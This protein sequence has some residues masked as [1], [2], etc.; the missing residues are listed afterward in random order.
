MIC[1]QNGKD[2]LAKSNYSIF[3]H[4]F[5][6]D[7]LTEQSMKQS[8][9]H[10]RHRKRHEL[11]LTISQI[12]FPQSPLTISSA[13]CCWRSHQKTATRFNR[14]QFKFAGLDVYQDYSNHYWYCRLFDLPMLLIGLMNW[15]LHIGT[16]M[17]S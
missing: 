9:S 14:M 11:F 10:R 17:R 6:Q 16:A 7:H 1:N 12:S 13:T 5:V 3:P 4:L 15:T 2:R 8:L